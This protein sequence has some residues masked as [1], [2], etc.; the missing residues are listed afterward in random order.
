[1]SEHGGLPAPVRV[2]VVIPLYN[3]ADHVRRAVDSVLAQ[4]LRDFE[5]IIVD[6]G[7]TDGGG[8]IVRQ[9]ADPRVRV[10]RQP[11]AGESAARN[12][13]IA[14]AHGTWIGL[15]DSDDEWMPEFLALTVGLAVSHP[16][17]AAVLANIV[18]VRQGRPWLAC[19]RAEPHILDNYFAFSLQNGGRGMTSSSSLVRKEILER[20]GGFPVGIHRSGD[21]DTW[22]RLSLAGAVG[23]VPNVLAVYHNELAGSSTQFPKPFF[24]QAVKTLRRLRV[25]GRIPVRSEAYAWRL[26]NQYLV[27]YANDLISYGDRREA[28]RVLLHECSVRYCPPGRFAKALLRSSGA[29][30]RVSGLRAR[31]RRHP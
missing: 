17:L 7:S 26:E 28:R 6:D 24:H 2:S 16:S 11:N 3:R 29:G 18:D 23:C 8:D 9:F 15:L 5:L 13:G 22:I 19:R 12:R 14:E 10:V 31:A 1:M 21:V 4:T 25:E 30:H 27:D 20:V